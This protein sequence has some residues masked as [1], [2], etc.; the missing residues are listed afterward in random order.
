MWE[1]GG[2]CHLCSGKCPRNEVGFYVVGMSTVCVNN[3]LSRS[4]KNYMTLRII[5]V[6]TYSIL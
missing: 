3:L 2:G 5:L 4:L 6:L 1:K